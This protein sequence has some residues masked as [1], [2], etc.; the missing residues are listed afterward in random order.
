ME[1]E[2]KKRINKYS[3]IFSLIF[4]GITFILLISGVVGEHSLFVYKTKLVCQ[5]LGYN[6]DGV[7]SNIGSYGPEVFNFHSSEHP[8][9]PILTGWLVL[10]NPGWN[11]LFYLISY[12]ILLIIYFM[13]IKGILILKE[14]FSKKIFLIFA[15]I[16]FLFVLIAVISIWNY[17]PC[18]SIGSSD[19]NDCMN[20]FAYASIFNEKS[21][22]LQ[23]IGQETYCKG[24]ELI[25]INNPEACLERYSP[26][27]FVQRRC[28]LQIASDCNCYFRINEDGSLYNYPKPGYID[29]RNLQC[30][31]NL[32]NV[33]TLKLTILRPYK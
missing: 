19:K 6:A 5:D 9:C 21:Y 33:S 16:V 20:A 24:T 17:N 15:I 10:V 3:L 14:K 1:A 23:K 18:W 12:F 7:Y 27:S 11:I 22:C 30:C 8:L 31:N 28:L 2:I 13:I 26:G 29:S 4:L 32:L 25:S